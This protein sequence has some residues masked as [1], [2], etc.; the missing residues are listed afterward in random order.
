MAKKT[1]KKKPVKKSAKKVAAVPM[2]DWRALWAEEQKKREEAKKTARKELKRIAAELR[3]KGIT[4][5]HCSYNGEGDSGGIQYT[6]YEKLDAFGPKDKKDFSEKDQEIIEFLASE[7]LPAGFENNDG[8]FGDVTF[9]L[10]N[11]EI[12]V[13]H[14]ERIVET[15]DH[16][17]KYEFYPKEKEETE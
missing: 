3:A 9:D 10:E 13:E 16:T 7:Y 1:T 5:L 15:T 6:W 4:K 17:Y 8:G 2:P 11:A 12:T 14:S